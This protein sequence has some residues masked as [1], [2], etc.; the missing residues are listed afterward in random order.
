[1]KVKHIITTFGAILGS[2]ALAQGAGA[3]VTYRSS[4]DVQFTF[5]SMLGLTVSDDFLIDNLVPGTSDTSN[6][7]NAIVTTNNSAGYELSATVGN[8]TYD[9]TA[10]MATIGTAHP[11]IDMTTGTSRS[12]GKWGLTLNDGT[13][14]TPLSRT[15]DTILNKTIDKD[16]TPASGYTGTNT[17]SMKIGAYAATSQAPGQYRNVINFKVVSNVLTHTVTLSRGD[18][19]ATVKLG[20]GAASTSDVSGT[21]GEG[22]SVEIVATCASGYDFSGWALEDDF[23]TIADASSLS[24]TYTVG[25]GNVTIKPYCLQASS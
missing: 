10:L 23:G 18:N 1:M 6:L 11:T 15:T 25:L 7:V 21:Y 4:S 19:A 8:S 17:T 16:A 2:L 3:I 12:S 24:T 9:S 13:S 5:S 20:S 14:Y 22:D